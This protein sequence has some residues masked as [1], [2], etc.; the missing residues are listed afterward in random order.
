MVEVADDRYATGSG[1]SPPLHAPRPEVE[2]VTAAK[3]TRRQ[4]EAATVITADARCTPVLVRAAIVGKARMPRAALEILAP[5]GAVIGNVALPNT[6]ADFDL[7][8]RFWLVGDPTPGS[9]VAIVAEGGRQIILPG[10][11][12][13]SG[14]AEGQDWSG[15]ACRMLGWERRVAPTDA[16]A[17][18]QAVFSS[19]HPTIDGPGFTKAVRRFRTAAVTIPLVFFGFCFPFLFVIP[20]L[21]QSGTSTL[22]LLVLPVLG[23]GLMTMWSAHCR[24]EVA[25]QAEL[26]EGGAARWGKEIAFT[27][28]YWASMRKPSAAWDGPM[29]AAAV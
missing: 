2:V 4:R 27:Q 29:P 13:R 16:P 14:P 26:V 1:A 25:A 24:R 12:L 18:F 20:R 11:R 6:S 22:S 5:N 3:R 9:V 28:S 7:H 15:V 19:D 21:V 10:S 8:Q 23:G 17:G